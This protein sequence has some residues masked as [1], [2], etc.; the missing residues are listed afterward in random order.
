MDN[1]FESKV[2][3]LV[4]LNFFLHFF[5]ALKLHRIRACLSITMII[6]L[7]CI[8]YTETAMKGG[9][10]NYVFKLHNQA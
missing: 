10:L 1:I 5:Y 8:K 6:L 4:D 3:S 2:S 9:I 7:D